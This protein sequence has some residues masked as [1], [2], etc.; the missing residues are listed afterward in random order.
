[1]R[2]FKSKTAKDLLLQLSP[3][4]VGKTTLIKEIIDTRGG[5]F[6]TFDDIVAAIG[7]RED[8]VGFVDSDPNRL[9]TIDEVQ[10]VPGLIL[11]LK[12]IGDRDTR[13][14][15]FLLTGL[16]NLLKLSAMRTSSWAY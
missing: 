5:R 3:R 11:A 16:A 14:G 6:V 10:R 1:M 7:A 4:Q 13:P 15:R 12:Y 9:L 2:S 8:P